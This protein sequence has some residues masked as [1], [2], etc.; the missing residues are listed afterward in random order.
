VRRAICDNTANEQ[1]EE[2]VRN[3][4]LLSLL[5]LIALA[6][7]ARSEQADPVTVLTN[8]LKAHAPDKWELR[9]RWRDGQLLASVTP[10][11]YQQAFDLWYDTPKLMDALASLCPGPGEEIWKLIGVE[12]DVILEPTVGGKSAVEARVNCRKVN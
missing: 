7:P 5:L 3:L 12:Q 8:E 4:T 9:V 11:P 2:I 6:S 10:W 1:K